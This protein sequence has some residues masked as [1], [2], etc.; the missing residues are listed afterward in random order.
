MPGVSDLWVLNASP[1][2]TL[3]KVDQLPLVERLASRVLVPDA[4]AA[5]ILAGPA[6]DP[7]RDVMEKGWGT[8]VSATSITPLLL[9]WGL[10]AGETAVLAVALDRQPCTAALDDA[11]ARMCARSLGVPLIGTLGIV[12]RAKER[13]LIPSAA[14]IMRTLRASGLRLD[15]ETIRAALRGVGEGWNG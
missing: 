5:E 15:D 8:R 10:G 2:I 13:G 1:I 7:A 11:S 14:D 4:V 12:V 6:T 3:A 9:A